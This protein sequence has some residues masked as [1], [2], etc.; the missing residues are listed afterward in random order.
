MKKYEI[1][2]RK[3]SS[4]KFTVRFTKEIKQKMREIAKTCEI[5]AKSLV[6]SLFL[7]EIENFQIM[8]EK[9]KQNSMIFLKIPKKV[10]PQRS[11][12]HP[13]FPGTL[14]WVTP[15]KT[16]QSGVLHHSVSLSTQ[17]G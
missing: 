15:F 6:F 13:S 10:D 12:K 11:K 3:K 14:P 16:P 7:R 4:S 8:F 9:S 17:I 1:F 5:Q 2:A